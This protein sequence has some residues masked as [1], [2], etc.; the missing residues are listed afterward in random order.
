MVSSSETTPKRSNT[1]SAPMNTTT[2]G[3]RI[4]AITMNMQKTVM[5]VTQA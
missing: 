3:I 4:L 2:A 5:S 1:V